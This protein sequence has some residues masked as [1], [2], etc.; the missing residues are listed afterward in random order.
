MMGKITKQ[1]RLRAIAKEA[2]RPIIGGKQIAEHMGYSRQYFTSVFAQDM[3][4]KNCLFIRD[5][6]KRGRL[7]TT[8]L[9]INYY[10]TLCDKF[11]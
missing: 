1:E 8:P 11:K 9:F 3:K 4:D 10:Y 5:R 2:Y 7:W 6:K